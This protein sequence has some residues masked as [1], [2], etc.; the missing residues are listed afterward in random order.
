M[1]E[2][3]PKPLELGFSKAVGVARAR[4]GRTSLA[5][6]NVGGRARLS[7]AP[8]GRVEDDWQEPTPQAA[9]SRDIDK[10]DDFRLESLPR[11]DA[12]KRARAQHGPADGVGFGQGLPRVVALKVGRPNTAAARRESLRGRCG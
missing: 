9:A 8:H 7:V 6:G 11:W 2:K 10:P 5:L 1:A 4:A 3:S 12:G